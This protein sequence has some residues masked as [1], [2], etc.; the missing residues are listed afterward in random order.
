MHILKDPV[1]GSSGHAHFGRLVVNPVE[2]LQLALGEFG[3]VPF[4]QQ[5]Y[6]AKSPAVAGTPGY[7]CLTEELL[8]K[9]RI[10]A[11]A[12]EILVA[13]SNDDASH[14]VAWFT[15]MRPQSYVP[16]WFRLFAFTCARDSLHIMTII[17]L[18]MSGDN[19]CAFMIGKY[20]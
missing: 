19:P 1:P 7:V 5:L 15:C 17:F 6:D 3:T 2:E 10:R 14:G 13:G 20:C 18:T 16:F 9:L 12:L 11:T 4:A 8:L